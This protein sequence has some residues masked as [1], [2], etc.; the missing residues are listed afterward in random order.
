[1]INQNDAAP[2]RVRITLRMTTAQ[3]D[4]LRRAAEASG[5][6]LS[7][8]V[9]DSACKAAED[10][11]RNKA[12]EAGH[13]M[14]NAQ[15]RAAM[16]EARAMLTGGSHAANDHGPAVESLPNFTRPARQRWEAIPAHIRQRLLSSVWCGQCGRAVT[17]TDFSGTMKG[18]DLLLVGR[19]AECQR[20]VARAI[21]R[22]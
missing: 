11:L 8:F 2:D 10:L 19:C 6:S 1:M 4:L 12:C 15:T 13:R 5:M 21:E 3:R 16:E 17:I 18:G 9:L 22:K 7:A 14:P 20:E